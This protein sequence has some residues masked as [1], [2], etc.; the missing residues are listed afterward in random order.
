MNVTKSL[1]CA[2]TEKERDQSGG[3]QLIAAKRSC[4]WS[5]ASTLATPCPHHRTAHHQDISA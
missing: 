3:A 4:G 1:S 2:A 5:R